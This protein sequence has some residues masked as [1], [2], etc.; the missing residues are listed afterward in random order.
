MRFVNEQWVYYT[1]WLMMGS[2]FDKRFGFV[3]R[4]LKGL[5]KLSPL[6]VA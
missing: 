3:I 4:K 5:E 2:N 1:K 6:L